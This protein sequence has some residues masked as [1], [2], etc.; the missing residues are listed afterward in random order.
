MMSND[1]L[2]ITQ[3]QEVAL[4]DIF[5]KEDKTDKDSQLWITDN[6]AS[7]ALKKITRAFCEEGNIENNP[8]L[9]L[10]VE[11]CIKRSGALGIKRAEEVGSAKW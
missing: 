9:A 1:A 4:A 6:A 3:V 10:A 5:F 11:L 7:G 8:C 2:C